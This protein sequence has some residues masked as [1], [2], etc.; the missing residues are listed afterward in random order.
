MVYTC[1]AVVHSGKL[2]I[3]YAMS[4]YST[5]FA[6]IALDEIM[7]ALKKEQ[8]SP[9]GKYAESEETSLK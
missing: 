3:P 2:L 6:T 1:G 4:D 8:E 9:M 7:E 5:G